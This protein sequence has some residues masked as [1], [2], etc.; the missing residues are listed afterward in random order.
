[1]SSEPNQLILSKKQQILNLMA[2]QPMTVKEIEDQL[3]IKRNLI[4][5][6]ISMWKK[7]GKVIETGDI[8]LKYKVYKLKDQMPKITVDTVI[9]KKIITKFVELGVNDIIFENQEIERISQLYKE[10]KK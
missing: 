6:Y 5:V 1:M 2:Q 8:R 4:W 3:R 9:L 7:E 10:V